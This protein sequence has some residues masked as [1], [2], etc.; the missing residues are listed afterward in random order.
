MKALIL[1]GSPKGR[2]SASN[3]LA[4]RLAGGLRA[5]GVSVRD[6]LVHAG[7]RSEDGARLLLE[8]VEASDLV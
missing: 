1:I 7:L 6:E 5:R 3:L 8:T 2:N 4:A